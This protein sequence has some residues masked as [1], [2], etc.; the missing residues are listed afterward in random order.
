ML[1]VAGEK[2]RACVSVQSEYPSAPSLSCFN[3]PQPCCPLT[4][5]SSLQQEGSQI[6]PP[7]GTSLCFPG[8]PCSWLQGASSS[9]KLGPECPVFAT[10]ES[11]ELVIF[12]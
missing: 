4:F 1:S 12:L 8:R 3:A 2:R 7:T 6:P 5:F 11:W 10:K 9:Q